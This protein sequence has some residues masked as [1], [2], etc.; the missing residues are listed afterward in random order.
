MSSKKITMNPFKWFGLFKH[1]P[2]KS[3]TP[4]QTQSRCWFKLSF[5]LAEAKQEQKSIAPLFFG[6]K[7]PICP[8]PDQTMHSSEMNIDLFAQRNYRQ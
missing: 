5:S 2:A 4:F 3:L 8:Y 1:H 6:I 7:L